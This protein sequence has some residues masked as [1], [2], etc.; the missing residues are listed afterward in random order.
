MKP[1]ALCSDLGSCRPSFPLPQPVGCD[2]ELQ[3]CACV[4]ARRRLCTSF[5]I[6]VSSLSQN[7]LYLLV[8]L[9]TIEI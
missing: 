5:L 4:A 2:V 3:M 9:P 6:G 1:S 7:V 8:A